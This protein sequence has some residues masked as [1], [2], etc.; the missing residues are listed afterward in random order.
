MNVRRI[1][2][3]RN[4]EGKSVFVSTDSAP[5]AH[6]YVHIPGMSS[7]QIWS[8]PSSPLLPSDVEDPTLTSRSVVPPVGGTQFVFLKLPPDSVMQSPHFDPSA[9]TE[10]N[11]KVISGLAEC[12]EPDGMHTTDTIDYGIVLDG[13]VWLELDDG[14]AEHLR[15][16]DVI[17]QNGTRH[18]WRNKSNRPA[19]LAFVLIGARRA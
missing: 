15:Q 2:T 14:R 3:G 12:F 6:D 11:K 16:H 7:T 4:G 8:T 5:N 17:I 1:V 18:A 13:E 10:E 9:A 19:L